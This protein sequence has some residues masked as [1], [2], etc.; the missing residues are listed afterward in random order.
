MALLAAIF[1]SRFFLTFSTEVNW[2]EFYYL[3]NTYEHMRGELLRPLQTLH[4]HAFAWLGSV[5]VNEVKQVAI[6]R[7]VMLALS[8]ATTIFLFEICRHFT[9]PL[10][11]LVAVLGY[12]SFSFVIRHGDS[13]RAD[14]IATALLMGALYIVICH[15]WH[16]IWFALAG[17]LIGISGLVTI[18]SALFIPFFA[19]VM[20]VSIFQS[21]ERIKAMAACAVA[22]FS[23]LAIFGTFYLLHK[24]SLPPQISSSGL[25][26]AS[27]GFTKTL[28]SEGLFPQSAI[29]IA[30]LS[31]NPLHVAAL[32]FGIIFLIVNSGKAGTNSKLRSLLQ[33]SFLLP[34]ITLIFYRNSYPYYYPMILAPA[35]VFFAIGAQA[36]ISNETGIADY[37]RLLLAVFALFLFLT[38]KNI[39]QAFERTSNVQRI[40]LDAIHKMFP[41]PVSYI[42][43]NSMVSSFPKKG[44]FMSSWGLENYKEAGVP[45]M[46]T[47]IS[48][49]QPAFLIANIETLDLRHPETTERLPPSRKLFKEDLEALRAN[50]IHHWG[51]IH[52]AGKHF[53][54]I[55]AQ[56][57]EEFSVLIEGTYTLEAARSLMI[58]GKTI[59]PGNQVFLNQGTHILQANSPDTNVILRLGKN[60]Y[61]PEYPAPDEPI[62]TGF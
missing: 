39:Y 7:L 32:V 17:I 2:D 29:L 13:F 34:L 41:E 12:A 38:G 40:T 23:A 37:R 59:D 53:K 56:S 57:E 28:F 33:F 42:D 6:A 22:F 43:R 45:V 5:S 48:E 51:F 36:F 14:P 31:T 9:S 46:P 18:K 19:C 15:R 60:L 26:I 3:S 58:D 54:E 4:V 47:I 24:S 27:G 20:L 11:A 35:A 55:S 25:E 62:Y 21:D 10:A 61:R 16:F 30:A 50:Y 44:F 1:V 8:I 52:V 49:S